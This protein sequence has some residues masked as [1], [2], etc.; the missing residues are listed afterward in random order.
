MEGKLGEPGIIEDKNGSRPFDY[1]KYL[2]KDDIYYTLNFTK[3]EVLSGGYGNPVKRALFKIKRSFVRKTK[4]VLAEPYAS[5]LSGLIVSGKEAMP[6]DILEEFRRAG[7]VN[8]V[9]LSGYNITI[10][11]EFIRT[12]FK[13]ARFSLV[14]ILLFVIMTGAQATVVRAALMVL[15]VMLAKMFHRKFS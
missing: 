7:V 14:G 13:S 2:S 12:V 10:I 6:K 4:E 11:A 5:L 8:I 15:A 3:V 1:S 9:V